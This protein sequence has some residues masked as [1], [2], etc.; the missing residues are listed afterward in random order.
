MEPSGT[1]TLVLG[2][3]AILISSIS[4]VSGSFLK[5]IVS[6]AIEDYF[7][8]WRAIKGNNNMFRESL[9]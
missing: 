5:F 1:K 7:L 8:P 2:D 3:E 9:G 6:S 4:E